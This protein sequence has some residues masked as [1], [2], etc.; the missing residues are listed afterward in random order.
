MKRFVL[1]L[2]ILFSSLFLIIWLSSLGTVRYS[3]F[4][5]LKIISGKLL[6][7]KAHL[8]MNLR[9]PRV[10]VGLLIGAGLAV[11]GDGLQLTLM[12]PLADPYIIGISA[13]AS[14]G[15][16]LSLVLKE[17]AGIFIS[18]EVLSF[19]FALISAFLVYYLAKRGGRVPV[20]SLILSGV[21]ISFLFNAA[22]TFL[23]V[24]AWKNV[25]S[26][27]FW[28]LGSLS[29][30]TWDDA[31]KLLPV[32]IAEVIIFFFL[33]QRML[34]IAMGEEH[35][36]TLGINPEKIKV[37]VFF[38]VALVSAISVA[39]AGLIGFVGLIIPH[40]TRLIFGVD[41]RFSLF[42]NVA[43]GGIFLIACD[44]FA[45]TFFQPT[46]LPIGAVTA[47]VGAPIFIYLMRRREAI[48]RE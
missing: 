16:V 33:R 46:E 3:L 29:G 37:T 34:I 18:M 40:I 19:I 38:T 6:G 36:I 17:S 41:S 28:S 22:V 9:L 5:V 24:F 45:R 4:E 25:L 2:L 8:Y 47:L 35:A 43:I 26:L 44:S 7:P 30:V 32:V 1:F 42:S 12:N 14:F 21:I 10:I 27:H 13:G 39:T 11:A 20:T 31:L 15:A 48:S 23:V